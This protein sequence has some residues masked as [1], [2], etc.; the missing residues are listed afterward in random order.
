MLTS[1][2]FPVMEQ[3]S[4]DG[5]NSRQE[6]AFEKAVVTFK[7][8]ETESLNTA[9]QEVGDNRLSVRTPW[10]GATKWLERFAGA[11]MNTL[12]ELAGNAKGKRDYLSMVEKEIGDLMEECHSGLRDLKSREWDRI[13]FWLKSTKKTVIH[14]KPLSVYIQQKTVQT[15]SAYWQR[16]TCFCLR[17]I[18]DPS[19]QPGG[20]N[21]GFNFTEEQQE[22]LM[23]LKSCYMFVDG[24]PQGPG[25]RRSKLLEWSM[26]CIR[27]DVHVVGVPVLVYFAGILGYDERSGQWKQP[28]NYTNIL[29]GLMWCMRV[30][31]LQYALPKSRRKDFRG[32]AAVSPIETFKAVRD[33]CLV[34][35]VDCPFS[36]FVALR[37]YGMTVAKDSVGEDRVQWSDDGQTLLF[38]GHLTSMDD[39]KS[40]VRDLLEEAEVM[41]A[42]QLLFQSNGSLPDVNIWEVQDDHRQLK[43]GYYFA[44]ERSGGWDGA[45]KQMGEWI[46]K[47]KDPMGLMGDEDED[48]VQGFVQT[49]VDKYNALDVSFR[50]VLYLLIL[51][52]AGSPPRGT[53]M[54]AMKF[55]NSRDGERDIKATLGRMMIVTTYHKSIGITGNANVTPLL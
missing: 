55:M 13:L 46:R 53:E 20:I 9:H 17:A 32:N 43:M 50:I 29:S 8:K 47:A 2:Y 25:I 1:S 10:L 23:S 30:L 34:E 37:N 49:A 24:S 14:S 6:S 33:T 16:F 36:S 42:N 44:S 3:D 39:W 28:V 15:Y 27:Q 54:T 38:W 7:H 21:H 4:T 12:S 41:L 35:E 18:D 26:L 51:F 31:V 5:H 22:L 19:C 40:F 52:T 45:R 11:N 48:G